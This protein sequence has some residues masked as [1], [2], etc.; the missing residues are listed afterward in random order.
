MSLKSRPSQESKNFTLQFWFFAFYLRKLKLV[1]D[2]KKKQEIC[3]WVLEKIV[4][5]YFLTPSRTKKNGKKQQFLDNL[6]IQ[7]R[8]DPTLRSVRLNSLAAN[9]MRITF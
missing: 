2:S 5:K 4:T 6:V 8:P 3:I 7:K 9:V 1:I